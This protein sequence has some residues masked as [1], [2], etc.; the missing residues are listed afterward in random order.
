VICLFDK[1]EEF[2]SVLPPLEW[3][4]VLATW[5]SIGGVERGA[6]CWLN[7]A[8]SLADPARG[9]PCLPLAKS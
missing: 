5:C 6:R 3:A 4:C 9:R 1:W 2:E 7:F 8:H